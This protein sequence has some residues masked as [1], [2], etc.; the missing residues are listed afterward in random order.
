MFPTIPVRCSMSADNEKPFEAKRHNRSS[1]FILNFTLPSLY[2]SIALQ[3]NLTHA[4]LLQKL[5]PS[6]RKPIRPVDPDILLESRDTRFQAYKSRQQK[7][8][9]RTIAMVL[10]GQELLLVIRSSS[11]HERHQTARFRSYRKPSFEFGYLVCKSVGHEQP[12]IQKKTNRKQK[13][14]RLQSCRTYVHP[15]VCEIFPALLV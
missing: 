4:R 1:L 7:I 9:T 15:F 6:I 11:S 13:P 10:V 5:N 14:A 3:I 8:Q 12:R 2:C